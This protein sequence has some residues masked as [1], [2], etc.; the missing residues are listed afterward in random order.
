M[1]ELIDRRST[2][3][4]FMDFQQA[5]LPRIG[6]AAAELLP[7]AA[8]VLAAAR[9]ASVFVAHVVIGFRPGYPEISERNQS[10]GAL[11]QT[12]LLAPGSPALAIVDALAPRGEEPIVTK[13]RVGAF[14]GTDLEMLLRAREIETLVLLGIATSG[15][16]LSTLRHAAD[17]DYRLVV[18]ED[19]CADADAE[20]HRV[21]MTKVF[22]RQAKVTT[23]DVLIAALGV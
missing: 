7:R 23:C 11:K 1:A 21:L 15:V 5:V 2:G 17:A 3:V 16:V 19:G 6:A 18:V 4:L 22:P 8:S 10:F 9:A 13:H 20:V 14:P 12:G